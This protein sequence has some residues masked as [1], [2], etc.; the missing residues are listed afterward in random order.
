MAKG[1]G[2]I[3]EVKRKDGGSYSPK[4]WKI[5]LDLGCD[6]ITGKRRVKSRT[7]EGTK[8]DAR[9][10]RDE[11]RR[12]LEQG[13]K[14]DSDKMTFREMCSLFMKERRF[15]GRVTEETAN[16]DQKRFDFVCEFIGEIPLKE[17]DA[18]VIESLYP[19]IRKRRQEC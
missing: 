2:S 1:D 16:A 8:T 10:K 13:I 17:I 3:I 4:H 6:P 12:E 7:V 18:Q 5:R 15:S 11:M 19:A 9:K 14:P